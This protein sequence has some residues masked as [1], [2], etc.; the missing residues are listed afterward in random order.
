MGAIRSEGRPSGVP[1]NHDEGG[2]LER[3]RSGPP[4]LVPLSRQAVSILRELYFFDGTDWLCFPLGVVFSFRE[5][6]VTYAQQC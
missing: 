6:R 2:K 5:I 1:R 3:K 4:H